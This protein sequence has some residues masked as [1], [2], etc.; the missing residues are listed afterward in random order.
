MKIRRFQTATDFLSIVRAALEA[1]EAANNLM[2]G[3]AL[4]LENHPERVQTPPYFSAVTGEGRLAAAALMTPPYNLVV[5]ADEDR[6]DAAFDL[7]VSDLLAGD[8]PV[9]GVFGP[10]AAAL[11]FARAWQR[12]AGQDFRLA[13]HE[14]VFEL[15]AVQ[16]HERP[17]GWMRA[18]LATDLE[19]CARWLWD[20]QAE[21][22]PEER[23]SLDDAREAMRQR[24]AEGDIYLWEDG[25]PVA[26]AG[27]TRPTPHGWTIGPVYTPPERRRKGYA[28]A[29]TAGLSQ[30]ILDAGKQFVSLFTDLANPVSNS[31]YQKIGFRPVCDFDMYRFA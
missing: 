31:I 4:R 26:L 12:A 1:N 10:A 6:A 14:R 17:A 11:A 21:A 5:L 30:L 7:V 23:Q 20:F 16:A 8:Q 3:L 27:R 15:R 2:Y 18:A 22:I 13:Y 28:T 24:I 29:L 25:V 19:I 9:P